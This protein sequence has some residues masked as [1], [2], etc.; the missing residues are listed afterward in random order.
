MLLN[1][2]SIIPDGIVCFFPSYAYADRVLQRWR[3]THLLDSI[4]KRKKES[5]KLNYSQ[6]KHE[7]L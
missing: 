6:H 3:D 2:C 1:F 5:I 7:I 4:S